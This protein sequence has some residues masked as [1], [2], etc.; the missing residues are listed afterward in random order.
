M[1]TVELHLRGKGWTPES[2]SSHGEDFCETEFGKMQAADSADMRRMGKKQEFRVRKPT[3][4]D[5]KHK[6]D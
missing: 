3:S 2:P 4:D 1:H 5:L 6:A